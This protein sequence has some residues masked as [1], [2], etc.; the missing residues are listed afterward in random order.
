MNLYHPKTFDNFSPLK[1]EGIEQNKIS[2]ESAKRVVETFL[3]S[4]YET[5]KSVSSIETPP[6]RPIL[7][8]KLEKNYHL[9]D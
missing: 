8:K 7:N 5:I 2:R 4:Q 9:R 6:Y 1:R 3:S